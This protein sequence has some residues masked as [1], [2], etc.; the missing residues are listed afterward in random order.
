MK[1]VYTNLLSVLA[2]VAMAFIVS[3]EGPEGPAGANGTDGTNGI[4]GSNG[5][6]GVATC[7]QCHNNDQVIVSKEVQ[8]NASVHATGTAF[9]RNSPECAPCHTSQGFL[10]VMASKTDVTA[11][12]ISNPTPTNCYTCHNI[13][14]EYTTD[15]WALTKTDAY[16]LR[17]V[18][19]TADIGTGNLCASCHQPLL[20]NPMPAV[21]GGDVVIT[22]P[23]WGPH[24]AAQGVFFAGKGAYEVG[25]GYTNSSHVS[26]VANSCVDCHMTDAYGAQAGGHQF[27]LTYEYHGSDAI[28]TAGCTSCHSDADALKTKISTAVD[29]IDVLLTQLET[30]LV[31]AGVITAAGARITPGTYSA[32]LAG[33]YI[34]YVMVNED[35]GAAI[36]NYNYVKKLLENTIA[37]IQ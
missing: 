34:N 6:S 13:H 1:K 8:Y 37:A 5:E 35:S 28:W 23:Y 12:T 27:G 32:D 21:G 16:S 31:T 24:H 4:D 30:E 11:A 26:M 9:E 25:T 22:S 33:A 2:I 7:S 36:H 3:C 20:P 10:E 29:A 14:S 17:I 19:A 15:D 18:D